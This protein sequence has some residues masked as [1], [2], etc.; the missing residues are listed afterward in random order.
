MAQKYL[1]TERSKQI[2]NFLEKAQEARGRLIFALDATASRQQTWDHACQL[3]GEMFKEAARIG[4]LEI[5]LVYY[6]GLE[7]FQH[8]GWTTKAQDG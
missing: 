2:A 4:G 6:R 1:P 7:E 8:S 5:Q 3:Q